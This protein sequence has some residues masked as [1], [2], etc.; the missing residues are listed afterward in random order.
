MADEVLRDAVGHV[1][2]SGEA[3]ELEVLGEL[4]LSPGRVLTPVESQA[5]ATVS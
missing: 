2:A 3:D 5:E 4:L 1:A